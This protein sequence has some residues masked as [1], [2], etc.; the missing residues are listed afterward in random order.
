MEQGLIHIYTGDGKGKTTAAVGLGIRSA[1]C[2]NQ[3]LM[4]QFLKTSK[5][6]ELA[7]DKMTNGLF[8]IKRFEKTRGFFWTLND[9]EKQAL[10]GEI[11]TAFDFCA[12]VAKSGKY[13]MLILDEIIGTIGNGLI[14]EDEVISLMKNKNSHTEL[15]LTGRNASEALIACADY[16]SEIKCIK[17]PMDK[18]VHARE[19]VEF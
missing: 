11:K 4:V 14:H 17:H 9:N 3:V 7:V 10:K 5:T 19:G 8:C 1:G 16:V 6:G 13:D 18:G 2:G 15:I 12:E